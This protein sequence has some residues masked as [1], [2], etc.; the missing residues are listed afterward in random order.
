[1]DD[2]DRTRIEIRVAAE[3]NAIQ[4]HEGTSDDTSR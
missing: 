2:D 4:D 3:E 1:M